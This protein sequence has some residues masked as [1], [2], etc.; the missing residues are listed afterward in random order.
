MKRLYSIEF[1]TDEGKPDGYFASL[2]DREAEKVKAHLEQA[3][4]TY[5]LGSPKVFPVD[6]DETPNFE[7]LMET[8]EERYPS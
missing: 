2:T 1:F 8:L 5:D 4:K 7:T 3:V 6:L